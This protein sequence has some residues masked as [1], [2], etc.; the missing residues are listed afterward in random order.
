LHACFAILTRVLAVL[1][2]DSLP[3]KTLKVF[4]CL[5]VNER[6]RDFTLIGGTALALQISHRKSEN[7]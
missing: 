2:L 6:L 5:A 3:E 1:R 4:E 7:G